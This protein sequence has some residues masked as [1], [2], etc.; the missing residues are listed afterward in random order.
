MQH[1]IDGGAT[2]LSTPL[3]G[4]AAPYCEL[5]TLEWRLT[6]SPMLLQQVALELALRYCGPKVLGSCV[7][8]SAALTVSRDE[9]ITP[10]AGP[11]TPVLISRG[12]LDDVITEED[13]AQTVAILR[14]ARPTCGLHVLVLPGKEHAMPRSYTEMRGIMEFW[15]HV[16]RSR[17][18]DDAVELTQ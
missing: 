8:M 17:P 5:M 11:H 9:D 2:L 10:C 6:H 1:G 18:P 3:C 7:A 13:V 15:S 4:G 16:L 14:H 12:T